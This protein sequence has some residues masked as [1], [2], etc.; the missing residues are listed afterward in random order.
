MKDSRYFIYIAV[1]IGI[2]LFSILSRTKTFDWRITLAH[3][4]KNPYGAYVLNRLLER[5]LHITNKTVYELQDSL[6]HQENLFILSQNFHADDVDSRALLK[7]ASEGSSIFIATNYFYGS[8]ADTLGVDLKFSLFNKNQFNSTDS[9]PLHLTNAHLDTTE[10][11]FFRRSAIDSYL[12]PTDTSVDK[13]KGIIQEVVARHENGQAAAVRVRVGKGQVVICAAPLIFSNIYLLNHRN[14]HLASS[15]LSYL[16]A[17][18]TY[19]TEYYQR[20]RR[21]VQSPLR[22]VLNS[23][24]LR[25]AYY[26]TMTTIFVFIFF[27]AK[28]KQR[29]IPVIKPLANTT[30]DFVR[31]IAGL[32]F[33]HGDHK[34]MAMKKIL[35]F[36]EIL[37]TRFNFN[38]PLQ[39]DGYKET[40]V[41]K[42]G[43]SEEKVSKLTD[44]MR[45]ILS[46]QQITA[47][48]LMT[49]NQRIQQFWNN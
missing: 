38:L 40:L 27:E 46:K 20:G 8:L 10:T 24:P 30:L 19:W 36:Q 43:V 17:K 13:M 6:H 14:H 11:F 22:Y 1:L 35:Y 41:A 23:E 2:L 44:T 39:A 48:E 26:L 34:N 18:A 21:E 49:L 47:E 4:D 5:P 16:P 15:L 28:R 45:S 37:R 33:E 32:Y 42:S 12:A 9:I 3:E 7:L 31:S 25:W 29:I